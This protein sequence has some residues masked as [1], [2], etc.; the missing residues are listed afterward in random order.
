MKKFSDYSEFVEKRKKEIEEEN[1]KWE[2]EE[3]RQYYFF[4]KNV[5]PALDYMSAEYTWFSYEVKETRNHPIYLSQSYDL[6]LNDAHGFQH[7]RY[8]FHVKLNIHERHNNLEL[9]ITNYNSDKE[10]ESFRNYNDM[11][12]EL[13]EHNITGLLMTL[14]EKDQN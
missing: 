8:L 9:K 14:Y 5:V 12:P 10:V 11:T 3:D 1:R 2:A 7:E 4:K 6:V 13:I